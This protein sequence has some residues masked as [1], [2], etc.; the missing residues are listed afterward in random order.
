MVNINTLANNVFA[1]N[2]KLKG[3]EAPAASVEA[4]YTE[5]S[6]MIDNADKRVQNSDWSK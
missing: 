6:E 2:R 5:D 1:S 3:N 4:L